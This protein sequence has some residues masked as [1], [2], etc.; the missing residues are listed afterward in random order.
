[1]NYK[2]AR[3]ASI[4]FIM[5]GIILILASF[6]LVKFGLFFILFIL[7]VVMFVISM[8]IKRIFYRCPHCQMQLPFPTPKIPTCCANCGNKMDI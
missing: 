1:M 4:I 6:L 7:G 5:I 8:I 2:I 3:K